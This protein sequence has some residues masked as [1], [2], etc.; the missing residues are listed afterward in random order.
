VAPKRFPCPWN[1]RRKLCTYLPLRLTFSQNGLD[2]RHIGVPLGVQA[3]KSFWTHPMVLHRDVV[4]VEARLG[5]FG[6]N[7]NLD[8]T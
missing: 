5:L 4:Q 3:Q 7:V 2:P 1:I 6:D 8:A